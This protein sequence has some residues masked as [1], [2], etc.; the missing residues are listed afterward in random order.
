MS[1]MI[2]GKIITLIEQR[3]SMAAGGKVLFLPWGIIEK[4]N[5][6]S[7]VHFISGYPGTDKFICEYDH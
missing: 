6:H 2:V 7:F 3:L 4:K 5:N 1:V